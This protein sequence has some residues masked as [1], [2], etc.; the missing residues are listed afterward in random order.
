M[1]AARELGDDTAEDLVNILG[2]DDQTRELTADQNGCGCF[3]ARRLDAEDCVSHDEP[4]LRFGAA[5]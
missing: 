2:Q 3:V 5:A 4:G 1:C